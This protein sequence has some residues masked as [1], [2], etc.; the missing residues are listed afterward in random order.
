MD[1]D[2]VAEIKAKA[3]I[4]EVVGEHVQ[5]K[6]AGRNF[7]GNC[8]FHQEKTPSFIVSPEKQIY[9]CFGCNAGGDVI[10]FVQEV[11]GLDFP[12]ALELLGNKVGVKVEKTTRKGVDKSRLTSA[13]TKAA[14]AYFQTLVKSPAGKP[15]LDYLIRKRGLKKETIRV[16]KFGYSPKGPTFL[17][18]LL[19]KSFKPQELEKAGLAMYKNGRH[20]D[21]FRGRLML[22]IADVSGQI[23]G[24]TAR[25][26]DDSQ[27]KYFNSPDTEIYNKS[28]VI[29]GLDLAKEA[30]REA[31]EV[32][33][34]EGNMD[35][36]SSYQAGVK[37][38]VAAS[39]TSLTLEQLNTLARFTKNI[40]IA[41]DADSAGQAAT[42]RVI[43][44]AGQTELNLS[45]IPLDGGKDPDEIIKEKGVSGWKSQTER[46]I[47][48][49]DYMFDRILSSR[50]SK[51]SFDIKEMATKIATLITRMNDP[52]EQDTYIAKAAAGLGVLEKS[53]RDRVVI[54]QAQSQNQE[55][56]IKNQDG[57]GSTGSE[58]RTSK[59]EMLESHLIG[60][61]MAFPKHFIIVKREIKPED[62]ATEWVK[63]LYKKLIST[64]DKDCFDLPSLEK[65]STTAIITNAK[66]ATLQAEEE[67]GQTDEDKIAFELLTVIKRIKKLSLERE[68]RDLQIKIK[69]AESSGDE[70]TLA[71]LMSDFHKL[72][73]SQEG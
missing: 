52:V 39:G 56:G 2:Q 61:S 3:D 64:Y 17:T 53:I 48:V 11:N 34:V 62:I 38:V 47:Y 51:T 9:H 35:V 25:A 54:V 29:Y 22:P 49:Y 28:R 4:A 8:P 36:V 12:A 69:E 30:I 19:T 55:S 32:V 59:T 42:E 20:I 73:K 27:P 71:S 72:L 58:R 6:K 46:A 24:F 50:P 1:V 5:L 63:A 14:S 15:A 40:K 26:L 67:F 41:F 33:V 13:N 68:K 7:K 44:L 10:K 37:N 57:T 23:I 45:I 70:K 16:F 65:V 60:L 18:D 21:W 31:D 43:E 66:I